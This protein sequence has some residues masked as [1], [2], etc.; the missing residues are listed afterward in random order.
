[1]SLLCITNGHVVDPATGRDGKADIWIDKASGWIIDAPAEPPADVETIDAAGKVV[2]PG[3]VDIHVHFR[4]P[5]QTHKEDIGTGSRAAAAGGFTS[6]V[7]M[8]NTSPVADNAGTIQ[9][10]RDAAARKAVVR[11]YPTGCLTVGMAGESLAPIGSLKE[12]GIVAVTD[13]GKCVQNNEIMRRAV[14]YAHMFGLVVMDHC[15]DASMTAGAV[16]NEG[17]WSLRLGLKGWPSAAEDMMIA[18]NVVLSRHTGAHIHM[19]HV[20]TTYGVD[21]IRRAKK[22]GIRVSGEASPHH[23]FF[24]DADCA[25]YNTH[26]KMNPPLRTEADRQALIEGILDGTLD[27]LATDHAPHT[28]DEKD[29]EFDY[30]PFGIIGLETALPAYLEVLFHAGKCDLP[31]LIERMSLKPAQLLGL[32]AGT[33]AVGAPAD[34]VIFDPHE[35]HTIDATKGQSRSRNCPWDGHTLR[36][37]VH[38]TLVGGVTVWDGEQILDR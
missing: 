3:F 20:T 32:N 24:T 12:A 31:F 13:D 38:R 36:G 23:L 28:A 4:E 17:Y 16:M 9:R 35:V 19:Q 6:V 1:M 25:D 34:V 29:C 27:V 2:A 14:E 15:E 30:A 10:I 26:F 11:V 5:G 21:I 7:C 33:L 22:R 8:P 37:R 18:R